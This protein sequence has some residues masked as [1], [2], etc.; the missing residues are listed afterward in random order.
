MTDATCLFCAPAP[1]RLFFE[2]DLILGLWDAFPVSAGHALLVP[3]RHAASWFDATAEE[4]RAL[5]EAMN[6][7]GFIGEQLV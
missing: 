7:P 6:R 3:R 1:D 5:T 4:R 2:P